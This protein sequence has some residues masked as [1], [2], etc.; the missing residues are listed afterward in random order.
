MK[1]KFNQSFWSRSLQKVGIMRITKEQFVGVCWE[2]MRYQPDYRG[3]PIRFMPQDR[4]DLFLVFDSIDFDKAGTLSRGEVAGFCSVFLRSTT[5]ELIKAI[6]RVAGVSP[7]LRARHDPG[8]S[9]RHGA[10]VSETLHGYGL[11]GN[12]LRPQ[13]G[14][15]GD[16]DVV[17]D[18]VGQEYHRQLE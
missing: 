6:G 4:D 7:P 8:R 2:M 14:H 15:L 16:G 17:L 1:D 12:G 9:P 5:E 18:Q 10:D 13:C 11:Q 3:N